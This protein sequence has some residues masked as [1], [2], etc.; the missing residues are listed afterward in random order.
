M[1][2]HKKQK[3][4]PNQNNAKIIENTGELKLRLKNKIKIKCLD[5]IIARDIRMPR[6]K[7]IRRGQ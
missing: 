6:E 7:K 1:W 3:T 4:D 2:R 5:A